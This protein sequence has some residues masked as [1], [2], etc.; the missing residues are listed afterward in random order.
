MVHLKTNDTLDLTKHNIVGETMTDFA[1]S[2]VHNIA[3][4]KRY[5]GKSDIAICILGNL[6]W[7]IMKALTQTIEIVEVEGN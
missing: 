1:L 3:K 4:E 7:F 2:R 5:P 6:M